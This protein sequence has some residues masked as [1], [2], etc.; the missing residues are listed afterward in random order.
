MPAVPL[1][2]ASDESIVKRA[3]PRRNFNTKTLS[4]EYRIEKKVIFIWINL[5]L[6]F[7]TCFGQGLNNDY[8][9][10]NEDLKNIFK[11]Q[12]ID[13]FKFPFELK[14]G[15]YIS[16]SYCIYENG[17][18]KERC[19]LIEDFQIE[20]GFTIDHHLSRRDTTVFHRIY[21]MVQEDTL[22]IQVVV[23]GISMNRKVD[24]SKVEFSDCTASLN[25]NEKLPDKRDILSKYP[26]TIEVSI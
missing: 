14:K 19:N 5:F 9:F 8:Q 11:L 10:D 7:S 25:I 16:L 4:R 18:E 13:V 20:I 22:N 17:I 2:V 3:I 24:I 26:P 23:P 6:I 15:E 1:L 12:G 21:F